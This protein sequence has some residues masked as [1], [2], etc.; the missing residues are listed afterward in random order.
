MSSKAASGVQ[1]ATQNAVDG[2]GAALAK[3]P[4]AV[5]A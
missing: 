4:P 2:F 5:S 1:V 3:A